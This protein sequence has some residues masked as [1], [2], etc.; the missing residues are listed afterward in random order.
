M[1]KKITSTAL[2]ALMIAGSTS[3]SAFAAMSNGTVVIGD[4]AFDLAYA[5]D[6][7]NLTEITNAMVAGGA[8]YVK[9]FEGNWINNVTGT[10][11]AASV[12][13]AVTYKSS[14]G[15]VTNYPAADKDSAAVTVTNNGAKSF[16][17]TFSAEVTD[18]SKVVF[19]VKQGLSAV[20]SLTVVWNTAKT[21]ATLNNTS[22]LPIGEYTVNVVNGTTDLGTTKLSVVEQKIAK[23]NI[24]STKLGINNSVRKN[25]NDF[26]VGFV[27]YQVL[28]QF[29]NDI[30]Q[31][32]IANSLTFKCGLG[33]VEGK[34]GVIKLTPNM[35][36][37]QFTSV[38]ISA[39][40]SGS[41]TNTSA[42]LPVSTESGTLS[43]INLTALTNADNKV[44]TA[45][46]TSTVF[47]VAYTATD[48]SGNPTTD[49]DL[50]KNGL[51][52]NDN[53]ELTASSSYLT[54]KI[55]H[56][57]KDSKKAAIQVQVKNATD[58]LQQDMPNVQIVA[59][60]YTGKNSQLMVTLKKAAV[61]DS[62]Q[63][64][65]PSFNIAVG[66]NEIIPFIAL[67]Q[68]GKVLTK[69]VD[70]VQLGVLISG[71]HWV[72]NTDGTASL[73]VGDMDG[74][75]YPNEGQRVITVA[76]DTSK[77]SSININIQK[78]VMADTLSLD[79]TAFKTIMQVGQES[80]KAEQLL[81]FGWD[82][83]GLSVKDQ[84]D[85]EVDMTTGTMANKDEGRYY[86]IAESSN[87]N[88]VAVTN[89]DG[90]EKLITDNK[91]STGKGYIALTA[92]KAG[93]ATITFKLYNTDPTKAD[94]TN[95]DPLVP[96]DTQ[97][98]TFS[99]LANDDIKDYVISER[100]EPIYA[101][102]DH[103]T[104]TVSD[105]QVDYKAGVKVF[106]TTASG[107]QVILSGE[108]IFQAKV[109]SKDF[110]IIRGPET[111]GGTCKYDKVR[112]VA[113]DFADSMKTA[114]STKLE[115][116]FMGADD[117][118][119]AR[120][121]TIKSTTVDPE[122]KSIYAHVSTE[123]FGISEQDD[124]IT[125]AQSAGNSYADMLGN[126]LAQYDANGKAGTTQ[127]VY[128]A[129]EDQY[130]TDS[131]ALSA[132]KVVPNETKL[133]TGSTF[134]LA[135]DGTITSMDVKPG[136]FV[137]VSGV[138]NGKVK[139][140]KIVFAGTTAAD[141]ET[142]K[143]ATATT[144]V[145]K[146]EASKLAVDK[147][148]AQTAVDLLATA[149]VKTDLQA[150]VSKIVTLEDNLAAATAA[151]VKAEKS[152]LQADVDAAKLLVTALPTGTDKT[153]LQDKITAIVITVTVEWV[154][155]PSYKG[156]TTTIKGTVDAT[157]V[158]S[159]KATVAGKEIVAV[160]INADGTFVIDMNDV[161]L[162]AT[163]VVKAY[164]ANAKE[165][166]SKDV[167]RGL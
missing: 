34:N 4:K 122:A 42:I 22:N 25:S 12:I 166:N 113:L 1:N 63:L 45:E 87:S 98:Q 30:T 74:K 127:N 148:A 70:I 83:G 147:T 94:G 93:T 13:P 119:Y 57:P 114:S 99:V 36:I 95:R 92:D 17:A 67:D 104:K 16:K 71:A 108:P 66:E 75:G 19:T 84:Y 47:Y 150:R 132:F 109:D 6:A 65:S 134:V 73:R 124:V 163:V 103:V 37:L 126:S 156:I 158:K 151:V 157:K 140:I 40:D 116:S 2:A 101:N 139:T 153:A 80:G 161:E 128:I 54:T 69:Y 138:V 38:T 144:A 52:L 100:T 49:Y 90:D 123:V 44:L 39:F 46:D 23:I 88:V 131:M 91:L 29:G 8:I 77:P 112:V 78:K 76:T 18:T 111:L 135:N 86:V 155:S 14:T 154:A 20:K 165:V 79:T 26:G 28:D 5:N 137:T 31:A 85:R 56:D 61:I 43:A 59:M 107:A 141:S 27:T 50:V 146:A 130:D 89:K 117:K 164:D 62:I 64:L 143:I 120:S 106:G 81:D 133:A 102:V 110:K 11:V 32:P 10:T 118:V 9:N 142:T 60:T 24:T 3:F 159:V 68:N 125:L 149:T 152:K 96:V 82:N 55:V 105:R 160:T 167:I 7:K 21:E 58:I 51:I 53:D 97:S 35:N 162:G 15:V 41:G 129:A 136:D 145:V 72:R 121:T 33:N 48:I 115:V